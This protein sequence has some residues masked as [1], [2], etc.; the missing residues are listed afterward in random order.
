MDDLD[1]CGWSIVVGPDNH[2]VIT[3][4]TINSDG[5]ADY[6]TFKLHNDDRSTIWI[7]SWPGAINNIDERAGWLSV[8]DN[9]DIIMANRTWSSATSYDAVLHRYA[10]TNGDTLWTRTYGGDETDVA[11]SVAQ[12]WI[13]FEPSC[14]ASRTGATPFLD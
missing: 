9:G 10:E 12:T 11:R 7:E 13:A 3:G 8:C 4:V 1:D 5:T 2:P 14:R 6:T